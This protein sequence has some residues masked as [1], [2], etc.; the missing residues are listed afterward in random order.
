MNKQAY[1]EQIKKYI[2]ELPL[3]PLD[4]SQP[5]VYNP[6]ASAFAAGEEGAAVDAGSLVSFVSGLTVLHKS[7]VLNST[8]LAQLAASK[9]FDRF[10]QTRD[11]YGK[12]CEV[13]AQV[14]W[15]VPT[16][17]YREYSPSGDSLQLSD[18][19]LDILSAIATGDEMKIVQATLTSLR[20]KPGNTGPLTLFENQSFPE[21]VGTFQILP[22]GEDDG[23]L[24]M[25]LT[26]LEFKSEKHVTR[27]LWFSWTRTTVK[28][29]Q[30]A[31]KS[32]LNEDVYK[33]VR[34]EV[35]DKLGDR[36]SQYIKDLEI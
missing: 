34:Q 35:I 5:F 14:G 28:L 26:A 9:A 13:L 15:V 12:Y 17:A 1:I 8:L 6:K 36:A 25:V 3:A 4:S 18:A 19:V 32:V 24:V 22:V 10:K 21:N 16:F 33:Q 2:K 27:F 7:D 30:S 29:F 31:Q 23:Q 11:W 20:D